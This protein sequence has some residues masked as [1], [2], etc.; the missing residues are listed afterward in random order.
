MDV[1]KTCPIK[2]PEY[3]DAGLEM[4]LPELPRG[5]I[6]YN[7]KDAKLRVGGSA[8]TFVA[9]FWD[10]SQEKY[11]ER[12]STWKLSYMD[13]ETL[14][15]SIILDYSKSKFAELSS[16]CPTSITLGDLKQDKSGSIIT[17]LSDKKDIFSIHVSQT[18]NALKLKCLQ[19]YDMV[20][21]TIVMSAQA[22]EQFTNEIKM[23]VVS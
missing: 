22:S 1:C 6:T 15:C 10:D 3:I 18:D 17:C 8:K 21:K 7:G 16:D 20:G 5:K 4:P 2:E 13:G 14:I 12:K 11:V 23:E 9:M 19:L